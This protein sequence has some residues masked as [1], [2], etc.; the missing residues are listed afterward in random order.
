MTCRPAGLGLTAAT[1]L[2]FAGP[3]K[4][5]N[6]LGVDNGDFGQRDVP[7]TLTE[8]YQPVFPGHRIVIG[9]Y[10]R[11]GAAQQHPRPEK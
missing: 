2:L 6:Y 9:L 7:K 4:R 3:P 8:G 11:S 10:G 5:A 1:R